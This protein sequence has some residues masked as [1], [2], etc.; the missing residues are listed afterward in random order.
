MRLPPVIEALSGSSTG[1][2]L[3]AFWADLP[4][5]VLANIALVASLFLSYTAYF[6]DSGTLALILSFPTAIVVAGMANAVSKTFDERSAGWRDF[7]GG[8]RKVALMLWALLVGL[9]LSFLLDTSG[10]LFVVH[11]IVALV[12]LMM[13]PF[14]LCISTLYPVPI[15]IA[16]RNAFV[17]TVHY[18]LVALGLLALAL[19]FGWIVVLTTGGLLLAMPALWVCIAMYS[20]R[21]IVT[22]L[23]A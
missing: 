12:V 17:M 1:R 14:V 7:F 10:V 16:W 3:L 13:M 15:R 21:E 18:P 20:T 11:C 6:L 19:L 8:Q 2:A 22:K 5:W 4:L 23:E 9:P